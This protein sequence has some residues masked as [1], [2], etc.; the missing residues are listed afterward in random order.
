MKN[1]SIILNNLIQYT[2]KRAGLKISLVPSGSLPI[3]PN[4]PTKARG[5]FNAA[6]LLLPQDKPQEA[7][8]ILIH[9]MGH[10]ARW[11]KN[12][13]EFAY[14]FSSQKKKGKW[15]MEAIVRHVQLEL[16]TLPY[17]LGFIEEAG[18]PELRNWYLKYFQADQEYIS[19]LKE[20]GIEPQVSL[21]NS[22]LQQIEAEVSDD[23]LQIESLPYPKKLIESDKSEVIYFI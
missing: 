12:Q 6:R 14:S 15:P 19:E 10:I 4:H 11:S 7:L 20:E 8:F 17:S 5:T 3:P 9:A 21:F 1:F 23:V 16:L 13:R 18:C 2:K 22:I